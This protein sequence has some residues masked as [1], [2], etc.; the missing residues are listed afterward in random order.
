MGNY[1]EI[2]QKWLDSPS[3]SESEWSELNAIS[4]D[5]K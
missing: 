2:Y 4:G 1:R 5:D 3:L